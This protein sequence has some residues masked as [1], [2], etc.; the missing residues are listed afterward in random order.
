MKKI[1]THSKEN[2]L[3][4]LKRI[5]PVEFEIHRG[6]INMARNLILTTDDEEFAN[7]I[8]NGYNEY[9][10]KKPKV[11]NEYNNPMFFRLWELKC[12]FP[13]RFESGATAKKDWYSYEI[14][15]KTKK[16]VEMSV[17]NGNHPVEENSTTHICKA[18]TKVRI[19]MVSRF[20]DV[21]ITDNIT[22][23]TGYG[24]RNIDPDTELTD[25]EFI[26]NK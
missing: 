2:K 6:E 13:K 4:L 20:G 18:G 8:V 26:E 9:V 5:N 11:F 12:S 7:D 23:P 15:A 21:G 22:N 10:K 1:N 3:V 25:F 19:W 24:A 14:Y 16:D 17:W